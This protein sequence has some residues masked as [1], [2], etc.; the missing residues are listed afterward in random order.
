MIDVSYNSCLFRIVE[1]SIQNYLVVAKNCQPI[2]TVQV[3]EMFQVD[4]LNFLTK[5][6]NMYYHERI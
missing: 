3:R 4:N 2:Q 1:K 5:I 6:Q